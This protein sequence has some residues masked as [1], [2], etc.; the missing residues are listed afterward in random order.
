[1]LET[2]CE[3]DV[4]CLFMGD[5]NTRFTL[6][7][8]CIKK[9]STKAL[10]ATDEGFGDVGQDDKY[11]DFY[12]TVAEKARN[13]DSND[14]LEN[15]VATESEKIVE[16]E[17]L[18]CEPRQ[19]FELKRDRT[20]IHLGLVS[21]ELTTVENINKFLRLNDY[22]AESL[23]AVDNDSKTHM[24]Q[25]VKKGICVTYKF[26]DKRGTGELVSVVDGKG[27]LMGEPDRICYCNISMEKCPYLMASMNV[28]KMNPQ[29]MNDHLPVIA[30]LE[31][32]RQ[33]VG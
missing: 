21:S 32:I 24:F 3:G 30:L 16:Q 15:L 9:N 11:C 14:E 18:T 4:H 6:T 19:D 31:P 20:L 23:K 13:P 26:D 22:F 2:C 8:E 12:R 7:E 17:T 33:K 25:P 28:T 5:Y 10:C 1:M 27:R 29:F